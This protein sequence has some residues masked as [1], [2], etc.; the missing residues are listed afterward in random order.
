M[1]SLL[2]KIFNVGF[3]ND[4]DQYEEYNQ[5]DD[6]DESYDDYEDTRRESRESNIININGDEKSTVVVIEPKTMLDACA[7]IQILKENKICVGKF[8]LS[9]SQDVQNIVDFI[10]GAV[11]ALNAY[12]EK[13]SDEIFIVAPA[14][15]EIKKTIREEARTTNNAFSFRKR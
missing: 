11:Y 4:E 2:N 13:I 10:S 7:I 6:Y 8:D 5:Y 1:S 3:E 15:V 14:N 12:M 9:N